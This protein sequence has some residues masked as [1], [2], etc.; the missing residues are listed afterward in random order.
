[1][2]TDFSRRPPPAFQ[3]RALVSDDH[4]VADDDEEIDVNDDDGDDKYA[5]HVE[6]EYEAKI[7][8]NTG[9]ENNCKQELS[10]TFASL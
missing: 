5:S 4:Y 2:L 9:D 8:L 10:K 6:T 3:T 7:M 1:M